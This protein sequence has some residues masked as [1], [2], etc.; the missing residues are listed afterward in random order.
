MVLKSVG[1]LS[2]INNIAIF[3]NGTG[4][5][6]YFNT[7]L[8]IKI[9]KLE[10]K[11]I[12]TNFNELNNNPNIALPGKDSVKDLLVYENN[13]YASFINEKTPSCYNIEVLR[14]KLSLNYISFT[15]FFQFDE[16]VETSIPR[17]NSHASGG[18]LVANENKNYTDY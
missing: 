7:S 8:I 13:I 2:Q 3:M 6:F 9:K 14:G 15:Y 5:I 11:S 18:K 16:C 10:F 17:F 1:Y 4:E 12:D